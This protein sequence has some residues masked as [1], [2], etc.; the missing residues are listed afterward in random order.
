MVNFEEV[1]K[2]AKAI[3]PQYNKVSKLGVKIIKVIDTKRGKLINAMFS[4]PYLKEDGT[5]PT[6]LF[7]S[8]WTD[9]DTD[10]QADLYKGKRINVSGSFSQSIN[11]YTGK[12]NLNINASEISIL[13]STHPALNYATNWCVRCY[14]NKQ[15]DF[16]D[17][18]VHALYCYKPSSKTNDGTRPQ[19]FYVMLSVDNDTLGREILKDININESY[20]MCS[21][22]IGFTSTDSNDI[23]INCSEIAERVFE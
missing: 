23:Y 10:I 8:I 9:K 13:D 18:N 1:L 21:G 5:Y 14:D 7:L 3:Q 17:N 12:L 4:S 2:N 19:P 6:P 16:G 22:E 11:T 20:L 15:F